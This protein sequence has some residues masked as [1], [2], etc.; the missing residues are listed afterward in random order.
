MRV[1]IWSDVICPWCYIGKRQFAAALESSGRAAEVEV[2]DRSFELDPGHPKDD[3]TPVRDVRMVK[4]RMTPE[5]VDETEAAM[6][7]RARGVGLEFSSDRVM[8][9]TFD[10]HR[11]IH[12]ASERGV[13]DQAVER[14]FRA[15]FTEGRPVFD[16]ADLTAL[17]VDSGLDPDEAGKV[18]A[19]GSY[20]DAV[21]ADEQQAAEL[22][23][24]GVPFFVLDG[25]YG[26]SGAQPVSTFSM[27]L[28]RAFTE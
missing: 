15:Y 3:H 10:A 9:N 18:L 8:G 22:G 2:V 7:E 17:A 14:L 12:L 26:V 11:L 25:R 27:A 28:E 6:A 19:D 16:Q 20:A 5:Q 13:Q 21:R 4:Y 24:S 1:D 23:I